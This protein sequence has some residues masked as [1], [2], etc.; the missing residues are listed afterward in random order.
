M[1]IRNGAGESIGFLV[2]SQLPRRGHVPTLV[3]SAGQVVEAAV[4]RYQVLLD[5][6]PTSVYLEPGDELFSYDSHD[7]LTGRLQ[8]RQHVGRIRIAVR[9]P[10]AE[11]A[12]IATIDVAPTK[13]EYAAEY[14]HMLGDIADIATEAVLQGF[15]PATLELAQ[16]SIA[17]AK[18]LYQ[19]FAF[20]NARLASR[21]VQDAL[22]LIVANP[23][24]AWHVESEP[25]SAGRPMPATSSLS[26]S[27]T[28]PGQ[29]V[30]THGRLRIASVPRALDRRR[31][32]STFD[33]VPNRFV[34]Y[35]LARWRSIAQRLIDVLGSSES[36]P[37][38]VR[39]GRVV[40]R[41]MQRDIDRVLANPLFAQVGRL[42]VFPSSNQ[43]LHRQQGYREIFRT[44]A[45][46]E[47]GSRLSLDLDVDDVFSA[48]QRNVATLY[49]YWAFLQLVEAV[50][51]VCGEPRTVDAFAIASDGLSL[52]FGQG[53]R[54]GVAWDTA[55]GG[56][57]LNVEVYFNRHFRAS[58]EPLRASS[59]SRAMRPD[60][61]VRI[62][63]QSP[64]PD[65]LP[66]SLDVWLHFD[67]KYR[68]DR[69]REQFDAGVDESDSTAGDEEA[70]ERVGG[71]KREDLLKMHA[72]RDAIR[73][74]AGAYVLYP[75]DDA[76]APFR[77]FDE[78][79]P[80]IGAFPLRPRDGA[81]ARG[82]EALER[83]LREVLDH[84]ADRASQDERYRYWRA[85]IRG[86]R[87]PGARSKWLP[88]LSA[89]PRDAFVLCYVP[90][91]P[92]EAD[93]IS[94]MQMIVLPADADSNAITAESSALRAEWLALEGGTTTLWTRDSAWFVQTREDL[95]QSG[96]PEPLAGGYLCASLSIV[97]AAPP[98]L[99]DLNVRALARSS[100]QSASFF[101][102]TWADLLAADASGIQDASIAA[103]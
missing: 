89:P 75:G 17:P 59:W 20:L 26:L 96:Y 51:A 70:A 42:E 46:A 9:V 60:C 68:V 83:F 6:R 92:E 33:S 69:V 87:E 100:D 61:S 94:R 58:K 18:L 28:R 95:L 82:R 102:L 3:G 40:A 72:Y 85:V 63:P 54:S 93:W 38:P 11:T 71:S 81:R 78:P 37:G 98:W 67:A 10:E 1:P 35:A 24:R 103:P 32:E 14:Q 15:A 97:R 41:D 101:R 56:R 13:L 7:C 66:G 88:S 64:P 48:S 21:E 47:V 45:L 52:G 80:G 57:R 86:R 8:P 62:R 36:G 77:E 25:Q 4:Y 2:L 27:V 23:H 90:R 91:G 22:A 5:E 55:A 34:K 43:V 73:G 31:T 65:V 49:E 12:G 76:A 74:S 30:D 16:D 99:A 84:V 79:L 39:R 53:R 19:Q 29:R 50:G 44:F